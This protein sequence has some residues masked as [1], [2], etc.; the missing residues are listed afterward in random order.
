MRHFLF[1]IA[2]VGSFALGYGLGVP[3]FIAAIP[4]A[5]TGLL[6]HLSENS[7]R[8]FVTATQRQAQIQK[9]IEQ[10]RAQKIET[11]REILKRT[12]APQTVMITQVQYPSLRIIAQDADKKRID[13]REPEATLIPR[14]LSA[15]PGK[16]IPAFEQIIIQYGNPPGMR[17]GLTGGGTMFVKDA[18]SLKGGVKEFIG[19]FMHEAGHVIDI[20][21]HQGTIS[22]KESAFRDGAIP[23]YLNDPSIEFY[24]DNWLDDRTQKPNVPSLN[25]VTGYAASDPF[26][27]FAESYHVFVL[28][29]EAFRTVAGKNAVLKKHY[30]FIAGRLYD[31]RDFE[32]GVDPAQLDKDPRVWDSTVMPITDKVVGSKL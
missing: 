1:L 10:L 24:N 11:S 3:A 22:A 29:G 13:L 5:D 32:S 19:V 8:S 27:E 2:C 15:L 25:F 28:Q 23:L 26:E 7:R 31:G 17:R 14:I 30:D 16:T 20:A 18:G 4:K 12:S 9:Q 21:Y 6:E